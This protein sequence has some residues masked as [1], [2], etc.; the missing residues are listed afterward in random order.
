MGANIS[1]FS[2]CG[3]REGKK[4]KKKNLAVHLMILN[5]ATASEQI[6]GRAV[7]RSLSSSTI[8][9]VFIS[10]SLWIHFLLFRTKMLLLS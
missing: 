7:Q 10:F 9:L 5:L 6:T 8:P 2:A 1:P 4:N 3:P